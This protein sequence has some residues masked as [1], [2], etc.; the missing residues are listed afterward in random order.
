MTEHTFE[1]THI[2]G[3]GDVAYGRAN[4]TETFTVGGVAPA[5]EDA[6]KVLGM[7]RRQ[8]DNAWLIAVWCWNS[9]LPVP[10]DASGAET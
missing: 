2:D 1:F 10:T 7:L 8:P 4:Y 3:Q 9:D 6:G 5:I